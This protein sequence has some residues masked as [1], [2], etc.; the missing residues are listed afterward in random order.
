MGSVKEELSERGARMMF[1][2][3]EMRLLSDHVTELSG[4]IIRGCYDR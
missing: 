2:S 1:G 4:W 3:D